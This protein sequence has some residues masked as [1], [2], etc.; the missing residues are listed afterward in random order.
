M[1]DQSCESNFRFGFLRATLWCGLGCFAFPH[2]ASAVDGADTPSKSCALDWSS[3]AGQSQQ[4]E[5]SFGEQ[6]LTLRTTGNDAYFWFDVPTRK[7]HDRDWVFTFQYFCAE[8]IARPQ[9]CVGHPARASR[10]VDLPPLV[11]AETWVTYTANLSRLPTSN[12][13]R[14]LLEPSNQPT[15]V[16]IDWGDQPDVTIKIRKPTL[17][18][19][20]PS[21]RERIDVATRLRETKRAT[22]K[23]IREARSKD[24]PLSISD[25]VRDGE[26]L[27]FDLSDNSAKA[28]ASD[29]FLLV[30]RFRGRLSQLPISANELKLAKPVAWEP[31]NENM[32]GSI[33]L[34]HD[35]PR[36]V[37]TRWQLFQFNET[38]S[39]ATPVSPAVYP[40]PLVPRDTV[41]Q[42]PKIL[43]AAKGLTCITPRLD[44]DELR[45]I[46]LEH[47]NINILL[48]GLVSESPG[49]NRT[50]MKFEG[51]RWYVDQ[52]RLR[53]IENDVQTASDAGCVVAGILLIARAGSNRSTLAHPDASRDGSYAMPNLTSEL[54][55]ARYAASLHVLAGHF[56]GH[57]TAR[58]RIDHWIVHNEVDYGWQ[59]T[60]MGEQPIELFMDHYVL[61]MRMVDSLVRSFNPH[62]RV[63]I[64]LTHR[65]NP[66]QNQTWRTYSPKQMIQWLVRDGQLAGDFPWGVAYHPYPQSLW[67]ANV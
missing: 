2:L 21:E 65:W 39:A 51:R 62:A 13:L 9:I 45:E 63:F 6:T 3:V 14:E 12:R 4:L 8:G 54:G 10:L 37:G 40:A 5:S 34:D 44:P 66:S 55:C 47:A 24:W 18:T 52:R 50:L 61:S 19:I 27:R 64:S 67:K 26:R 11:P 30:P 16:R 17:R 23:M 43:R 22:A 57:D 29:R 15:R 31:R 25:L 28:V 36:S 60:N 35:S 48:D 59:W 49:S 53:Q 38:R 7:K 56:G 58:G 33:R 1:R 32:T 20:S 42:P 41:V 46:G